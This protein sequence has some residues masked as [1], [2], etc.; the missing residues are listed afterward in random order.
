MISNLEK[1]N[2]IRLSSKSTQIN[3]GE[4]WQRVQHRNSRNKKS[5]IYL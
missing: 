2:E 4:P 5:D 3:R 1:E